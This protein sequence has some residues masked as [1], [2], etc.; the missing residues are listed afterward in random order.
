ML[1]LS[2]PSASKA[3]AHDR[4]DLFG[5]PARVASGHGALETARG[6]AVHPLALDA[7]L[8]GK[9]LGR[10]AH[11]DA[12]GRVV[13]R[14][15]QEILELDLAH[16]EA[17]AV[18]IGGDRIAAHRLGARRERQVDAA[19][20]HRVGRLGD[21]L[22][23]GAADA[24]HQMRRRFDGR[25]R[26]EPDM[27]RRDIGIERGLRHRAGDGGADIGGIDAGSLRWRPGPP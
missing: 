8:L 4:H 13:E 21:H 9:V 19:Q 2:M 27:A 1:A 7:V 3:L 14:L 6:E 17:V 23:P 16:G 5:K 15:P 18:G 10:V 26:I 20:R 25:A 22:D 11:G 24:L 12:A